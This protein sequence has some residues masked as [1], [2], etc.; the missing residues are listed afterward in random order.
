MRRR[1]KIGKVPACKNLMQPVQ[2]VDSE[3]QEG[4]KTATK[5]IC[6]KRKVA[7]SNLGN[8]LLRVRNPL[9]VCFQ[10]IDIMQ[11]AVPISMF[12]YDPGNIASY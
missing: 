10:H 6:K 7:V 3:V 2:K 12:L 11:V 4:V 1:S 5:S 8:F 9:R